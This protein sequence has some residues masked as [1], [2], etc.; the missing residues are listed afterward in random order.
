MKKNFVFL[1]IYRVLI[2]NILIA[3]PGEVQLVKQFTH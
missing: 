3:V 2:K 1:R